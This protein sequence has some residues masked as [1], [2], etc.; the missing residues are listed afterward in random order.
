M[1]RRRITDRL[2]ALCSAVQGACPDAREDLSTLC[3]GDVFEWVEQWLDD[4]DGGVV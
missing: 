1:K 2:V 3:W 4:A